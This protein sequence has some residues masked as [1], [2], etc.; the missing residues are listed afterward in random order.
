MSNTHGP[1][2]TPGTAG[3]PARIIDLESDGAPP[4]WKLV[5]LAEAG[6]LVVAFDPDRA[7]V[8]VVHGRPGAVLT[9]SLTAAGFLFLGAAGEAE[10]Y[11]RAVTPAPL[12]TAAEPLTVTVEEAARILGISR[13]LAYELARR[14]ELPVI[15]LGRRLVVPTARLRQMVAGAETTTRVG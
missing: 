10:A 5:P 4:G 15:R 8:T 2:I 9:A 12:V 14:H 11:V 7:E 13:G 6:R 3:I 1:A